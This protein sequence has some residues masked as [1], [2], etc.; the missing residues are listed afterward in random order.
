VSLAFCASSKRTRSV[1][2]AATPAAAAAVNPHPSYYYP[3]SLPSF[4][5]FFLSLYTHS[6]QHGKREGRGDIFF[7]FVYSLALLSSLLNNLLHVKKQPFF[8][9]FFPCVHA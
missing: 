1:P 5:S 7:L 8:S 3:P 2:P 4:Q 9:P 6:L